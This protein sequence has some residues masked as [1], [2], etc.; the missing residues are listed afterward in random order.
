[1]GDCTHAVFL[2]ALDQDVV[3]APIKGM[4]RC[5]IS[6]G[7]KELLDLGIGHT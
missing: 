1:M 7:R 2:F 5:L 3:I 6:N 4:L